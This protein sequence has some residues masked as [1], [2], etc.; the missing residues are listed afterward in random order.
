[1]NLCRNLSS[2]ALVT[3]ALSLISRDVW[4]S[5][6]AKFMGFARPTRNSYS[7]SKMKPLWHERRSIVQIEHAFAK[8]SKSRDPRGFALL[9]I[10][11]RAKCHLQRTTN[12]D[13]EFH[14]E[15]TIVGT[16]ISDMRFELCT[17]AWRDS[18]LDNDVRR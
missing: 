11:A 17:T 8:P 13:I 3:L 16:L 6:R 5:R 1:M 9:T 18:E 15:S 10:T 4:F 14:M 7:A 2:F 12:F